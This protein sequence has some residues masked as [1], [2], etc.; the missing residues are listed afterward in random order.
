MS[1]CVT[2]VVFKEWSNKDF[3]EINVGVDSSKPVGS[4]P[5]G[6]GKN[7]IVNGSLAFFA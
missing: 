7:R 4:F 2:I 1:S 5:Y 6:W 3:L